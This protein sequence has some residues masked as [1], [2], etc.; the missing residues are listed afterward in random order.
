[1]SENVAWTVDQSSIIRHLIE[2]QNGTVSAAIKEL[3]MNLIDKNSTKCEITL[4][5]TGFKVV[6]NGLGFKDLTD[7]KEHFGCFGKKHEDGDAIFGRFRIGRGQIMAL[8]VATWHSHEFKMVADYKNDPDGFQLS[9]DN[10]DYVDGCV[11]SGQFYEELDS[12]D[13]KGA[14]EEIGHYSK[15]LSVTVRLNGIIVN[16]DVGNLKWDYEDEHIFIRYDKKRVGDG[17]FLY[18]NGIFVKEIPSYVFGIGGDVVTKKP[19]LLNMSRNEVSSADPTFE[20]ISGVLRAEAVKA[21]R[22][23]KLT[24]TDNQRSAFIAQLLAGD[25][26]ISEGYKMSLFK[27]SRGNTFSL[28]SL[29]GRRIPI[30]VC[31]DDDPFSDAVGSSRSATVFQAS[32][33]SKWGVGTANELVQLLIDIV[34]DGHCRDHRLGWLSRKVEKLRTVEFEKLVLGLSSSMDILKPK[35][36]TKRE[37]CA[38]NAIQYAANMMATRISA[39]LDT[40][41]EPRKIFIG[42]SD[43]AHGWTDGLTYI[44]V[45]RKALEMMDAGEYGYTQIALLLLHEYCHDEADLTSHQHTPE[46]F[47]KFHTLSMTMSKKFEVVGH[48]AS[49]LRMKFSGE[50]GK[51]LLPNSA[52]CEASALH[53]STYKITMNKKNG[54]SVLGQQLLDRLCESKWISCNKKSNVILVSTARCE[55]HNVCVLN[56]LIKIANA[57]GVDVSEFDYDLAMQKDVLSGAKKDYKELRND[58]LKCT[59][60]KLRVWASKNGHCITAIEALVNLIQRYRNPVKALG[61]FLLNDSESQVVMVERLRTKCDSYFLKT[62]C[63]ETDIETSSVRV[64][65]ENRWGYDIGK[66][67]L[68]TSRKVRLAYVS[69]VVATALKTL[70]NDSE[71]EAAIESIRSDSFVSNIKENIN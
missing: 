62:K 42:Q 22:K 1:M 51:N 31:G 48:V 20:H 18:S 60:E 54:L 2:S 17:I 68:V 57:D 32:E 63:I 10:G 14:I 29:A 3:I 8:S 21:V 12:Y 41:I 33:L 23:S 13:L 50:V 61:E 67:D 30:T 6:D 58:H 25:L 34:E 43:V 56:E 71:M 45:N 46:F 47:D 65:D 70:K 26:S 55:E 39:V 35:D 44:A 53:L 40:T 49:S 28:Y 36:L 59:L 19:L 9:V 69:K 15:Y 7:V 4:T 11:V 5:K 66:G 16:E 37:K 24:L 64:V 27:D 52:G 38:R